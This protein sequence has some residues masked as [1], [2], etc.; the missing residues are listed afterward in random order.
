MWDL[1]ELFYPVNL[2]AASIYWYFN[3]ASM[4]P[5]TKTFVGKI[6]AVLTM[7]YFVSKMPW[8][9]LYFGAPLLLDETEWYVWDVMSTISILMG[10]TATFFKRTSLRVI[11][12]ILLAG[13][14]IKIIWEPIAVWKTD[15]LESVSERMGQTDT[16]YTKALL[17][18][19]IVPLFFCNESSRFIMERCE[20]VVFADSSSK[21]RKH[22]NDMDY[23]ATGPLE[24]I[25]DVCMDFLLIRTYQDDFK[26]YV[27]RDYVIRD[28][29][30]ILKT[31]L[32]DWEQCFTTPLNAFCMK[33]QADYREMLKRD[34]TGTPTE[35]I[36][37]IE[38]ERTAMRIRAAQNISRSWQE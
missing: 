31:I 6:R 26:P 7:G 12:L 14:L 13:I 3:E 36:F 16:N 22:F 21:F 9:F 15:C 24:M 19:A 8:I 33:N 11:S 29:L 38:R 1:K 32:E 28:T 30:T 35:W 34:F 17:Q 25:A 23:C 20:E 10:E 5:D 27:C 18:H 37:D 4:S 2:I